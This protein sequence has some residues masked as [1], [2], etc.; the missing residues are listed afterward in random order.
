MKQLEREGSLDCSTSVGRYMKRKDR[1]RIRIEEKQTV[2]EREKEKGGAEE[3]QKRVKKRIGGEPM[4]K[5]KTHQRCAG[6]ADVGESFEH[7]FR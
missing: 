5:E 6:K 7:L 4:Y 1:I 3:K 2:E